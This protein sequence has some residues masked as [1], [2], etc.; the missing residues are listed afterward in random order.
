M[1]GGDDRKTLG[2]EIWEQFCESLKSAA[3][4]L[5]RPELR[6][7]P[8]HQVAGGRYLAGLLDS[9]LDMWLH[10]ADRDRPDLFTVYNNW[11]GW[12][13]ANPD[14]RYQ[15]ARLRGDATYRIW[16]TRGSSP[17]LAF[18][19]SRG[20]WSYSKP[21]TIQGSLSSR[22]MVVSPDGTYEIILSR[23]PRAGNWLPLEADAEW[24]HIREFFHDWVDDEPAQ[25]FIERTDIDPGPPELT[26]TAL[27]QRL[28]DVAWFV[29]EEARLWVDYCVHMRAVQGA[30][31]LPRPTAPGGSPDDPTAASGARENEYSQGY[32]VLEENEALLVEFEPPPAPYWNIQI[33]SM[34]YESLDYAYRLQSYNDHQAFVGADGI[35]RAVLA[36]Q[37]P[38]LPNWLDTGGF[39]EGVVLCRFQFAERPA[40]QPAT[41]VVAFADLASVVPPETPRVDQAARRQEIARRRLG[42]ARRFR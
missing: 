41:R 34:W 27:Q 31:V 2:G 40:P 11:K 29:E 10:A 24:L 8:R 36:Q 21:A 32:Y 3:G 33:G 39:R 5:Q 14:G 16:G 6:A 20:I 38:G 13:F 26:S 42:V 25:V 22:N 12:S 15:R 23:A 28:A 35:F 1:S 7:D 30:N 4:V 19:L 37:D 18:E 9:A 17:Y